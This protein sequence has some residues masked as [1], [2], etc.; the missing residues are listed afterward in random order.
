MRKH[1]LIAIFVVLALACAAQEQTKKQVSPLN[2]TEPPKTPEGLL[3]FL[4]PDNSAYP[5]RLKEVPRQDA[6][7]ALIKAQADARGP[8]ADAIAFL[9]V[10]LDADADANRERLF[11][12]LR[13]CTRDPE[14]CD[15]RLL[16]YLGNLFDRGD[17]S[18]LDPLLEA[19]RATDSALV[20][21]LGSTYDDLVSR[22]SR[23]VI[24][25]T[26]RRPLKD[27][28]RICHMIATGDGTGLPDENVNEVI[29]SL[30]TMAREVGP[31]AST[32]MM[33]LSEIKAFGSR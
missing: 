27:Q 31:V 24:A 5:E 2:P 17:K 21:A 15:D 16:S 26:S 4:L 25:T 20:E 23:A 8:R 3:T 22:D 28:R 14:S 18:V 12:S 19:S 10:I 13:T 7:N 11:E 29:S 1:L 9:L 33:C 6:T 32:A 30:E